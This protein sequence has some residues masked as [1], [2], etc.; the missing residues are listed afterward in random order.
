MTTPEIL[1]LAR[2]KLLEVQ[3]DIVADDTL[4]IYAN[5]AFGD[6]IKRSFPN[7]SITSQV[8]NFV[9]G[10][11]DVPLDFGTLYTDAVDG[12]G[13]IY[14][15]VSIS[16]FARQ[17]GGRA[18]TVSGG[19]IKT[20]PSTTA[21]LTVSYYPTYPAL[22]LSQNP[23]INDYL[24]EPIVYGILERAFEDLQDPELSLFYKNKYEKML[25]DKL[26][27]LSVYEENAQ[28]GGVMF[29]PLTIIS[30]NNNSSPNTW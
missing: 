9:D 6:V 28:Y 16:G 5:L 2:L 7:S 21:S 17:N 23:T 13:N 3:D 18:I 4:L 12:F 22:S 14:P 11:V 8:L 10:E 27:N 30:P 29:N 26:S 15:E 1:Q 25:T 24:H 20:S 19:K